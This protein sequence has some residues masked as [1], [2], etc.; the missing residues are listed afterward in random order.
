MAQGRL[1]SSLAFKLVVALALLLAVALAGNTLLHK[2]RA[3]GFLGCSRSSLVS[4]TSACAGAV[5]AIEQ[6]NDSRSADQPEIRL[7]T[8]EACSNASAIIKELAAQGAVAVIGPVCNECTDSAIKAASE[9]D[10]L[11]LSPVVGARPAGD[12]TF[13]STYPSMQR[14]AEFVARHLARE[15]AMRVAIFAT[16][17][18]SPAAQQLKLAVGQLGAAQCTLYDLETS[19]E[20]GIVGIAGELANSSP[21]AVV[22]LASPAENALLAQHVRRRG[23]QGILATDEF[24]VTRDFFAFGGQAIE[25][26]TVFSSFRVEQVSDRYRDFVTQFTRRFNYPPDSAAVHS[27]DATKMVLTTIRDAQTRKD[28]RSALLAKQTFSGL[29]DR[30]SVRTDGD[31]R[32]EIIPVVIRDGQLSSRK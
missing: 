11:L 25:G 17:A 30:I 13:L 26:M 1:S 24:L 19:A 14:R 10:L 12:T 5:F 20:K 15:K 8:E 28:V 7:I 21:D 18:T 3:I 29:H 6:Y 16:T 22:L 31:V 4:T 32:R 27:Y 2:S 23:Y 9:E